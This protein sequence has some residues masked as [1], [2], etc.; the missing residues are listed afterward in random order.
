MTVTDIAPIRQR[1]DLGSHEDRLKAA[2]DMLPLLTAEADEGEKLTHLTDAAVGSMKDAGF[3]HLLLPRELGGEQSTYLDAMEIIE[4]LAWAD[5]SAGWYAMVANAAAA[6]LGAF[7]PDKGAEIIY[8]TNPRTMAA[9]QGVPRGTAKRVEGGYL[10]NGPWSY[11]STIF[12]AQY[13]H[14]GCAVLGADG[15]PILEADGAP[16]GILVHFPK[17]QGVLQ[18]NWD[19]LGLRG[20]GSYDYNVAKPDLFVPEYMTYAFTGEAPRRGGSQ[21]AIGIVG[22][23][24]WCHASWAI[25]V[26]RRALDEIRKLAPQK[27][28]PFGPLGNSV[29]FRQEYAAGESKYRAA[30][31][32][33]RDVWRDIDATLQSESSVSIE[34]IA[35]AKMAMR[36][37]HDVGSEVTT[38]AYRA[39][40]GVALRASLLQRAFRD[41]HAATQHLLLSDQ[42]YQECGRVMLG[43]TGKSGRWTTLKVIEE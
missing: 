22:F 43:M 33:L 38:F 19:T 24:A 26:T 12:H 6:S 28:G 14:C 5:G 32:F 41:M 30:R 18:G 23:T 36:H 34:Q 25:G 27:A 29:G 15:K 37:M 21:Y 17:E 7:L 35:L 9:G 11:G 42:I 16:K 10:V 20:T 1:V 31:A 8:G 3:L 40:G 2:Q 13:F 4:M 39:G